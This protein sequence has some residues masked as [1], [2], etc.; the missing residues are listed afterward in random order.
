MGLYLLLLVPFWVSFWIKAVFPFVFYSGMSLS[1]KNLF[2]LIS[3]LSW[4]ILNQTLCIPSEPVSFQFIFF[5]VA[6]SESMCIFAFGPT[7]SSSNS[8]HV[9]YPFGL[10]A[11]FSSFPYFALKLLCLR[12]FSHDLVVKFSFLVLESSVLSVLFYP[13]SISF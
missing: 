6:Q 7:S 8:T 11:M 10:S 3:S 9:A 5:S 1:C 12:A 13:V 4:N 2:I